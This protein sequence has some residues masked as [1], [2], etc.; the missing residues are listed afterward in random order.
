MSAISD[1]VDLSANRHGPVSA[2]APVDIAVV[3]LLWLV[4]LLPF[5]QALPFID[6][7]RD[8]QFAL[9]IAHG[10][11][12]PL[13]GPVFGNRFHLGPVFYYVQA[14]PLLIGL[15]IAAVPCFLGLLAGAK[16][17]LAYGFGRDWIDRRYGLLFA[18]AL[19][20]PGWSGM[21]FLNTTSPLLLPSLLLVACWCAL[22]FARAV[23]ASALLGCALA[24]S[25][26]IHAHP[27]AVVVGWVA[28]VVC[29]WR[30]ARERRWGL[31]AGAIGVGLL[32]L[33]PA[34]VAVV[35]TGPSAVLSDALTVTVPGSGHS[36]R[37]WLDAVHGFALGGP[38]TT[39]RT[40]GSADFGTA[41]AWI[42][43]G[44]TV[45]GLLLLLTRVS[46]DRR[47]SALALLLLGVGMAVFAARI[48]TPWYFVQS[49]TL[50]CAAAVAYGWHCWRPGLRFWVA[51]AA[52]LALSQGLLV[53]AH[54]ARGE[55][56]FASIELMDIRRA[57]GERGAALSPW[58]SVRHW[59]SLAALLCADPGRSLALHGALARA[60]DDQGALSAR[61]LCSP[62]HLQLGG[63]AER[64][65]VGLPRALWSALQWSPQGKI[66]S[67]G[68]FPPA[69]V[70]STQ[71]HRIADPRRYPLRATLGGDPESTVLRFTTTGDA[72]LVVGSLS[73]ALAFWRV[74]E[75]RADGMPIAPVY[76]D[77]SL[78]GY[79][80]QRGENVHWS[81]HISAS[82]LEWVDI[83]VVA[84][85]HSPP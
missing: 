30:V 55:G 25:L 43:L 65:W 49:L 70:L 39:L 19:A 6:G 48:N 16:F 67:I 46:D 68:L 61:A 33:L 73:P 17:A 75:V 14:L 84:P 60:V 12:F 71:G 74:D 37:G 10:D 79:R 11:A 58:I 44:V 27:S 53:H 63:V 35:Q 29:A 36:F 80:V 18:A 40:L 78:H 22:R 59:S 5:T 83:V 38:L 1:A 21:D 45:A 52:I 76:E 4:Y 28:V 34:M 42:T 9:D 31:L 23:R 24:I 8:M 47:A 26:A 72:L 50:M 69:T 66:G 64:H 3:G 62:D 57:G 56:N 15:P 2:L 20:L 32:P 7:V 77:S 54:L 82:A 85:Q 41:L 81:L 13:V 51:T